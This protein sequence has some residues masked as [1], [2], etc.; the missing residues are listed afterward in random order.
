MSNN[1]IPLDDQ[2]A[3]TIRAR[4]ATVFAQDLGLVNFLRFALPLMSYAELEDLYQRKPE[5]DFFEILARWDPETQTLR[6]DA[7][8]WADWRTIAK[9]VV[10][11]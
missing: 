2:S 11:S 5:H 8:P 3:A 9:Q 1:Q 6:D 4:E 10:G 7:L